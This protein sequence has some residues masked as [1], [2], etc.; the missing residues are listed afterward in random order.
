ME[1]KSALS[2]EYAI[3]QNEK[4]AITVYRIFDN[5]K[6]SL[7]EV[8]ELKGF[9]YDPK[10]PTRQL[11][12]KICKEF[13][14]GKNAQVGNYFIKVLNSGAIETYRTYDN[15]KGALREIADKIGFEYD[16]KWGTQ[17]FGSKLIDKLN[18]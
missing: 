11:G 8:A 12:T 17:Q 15:T 6:A 10:W 1:L 9:E 5:V 4:K 13:G 2:G 14:D 3:T 16:P 18:S 7:R